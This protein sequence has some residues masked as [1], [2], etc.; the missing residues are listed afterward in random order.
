VRAVLQPLAADAPA[1]VQ[2]VCPVPR[3]PEHEQDAE[4]GKR[5]ESEHERDLTFRAKPI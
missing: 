1:V 3:A 5:D 2:A 4:G